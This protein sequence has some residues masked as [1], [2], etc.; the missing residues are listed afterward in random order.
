[1]SPGRRSGSADDASSRT[2]DGS[3]RAGRPSLGQRRARC[4]CCCTW[5]RTQRANLLRQA[6][7]ADLGE[8]TAVRIDRVGDDLLVRHGVRGLPFRVTQGAD[9][10]PRI[11]I[12]AAQLV[13]LGFEPGLY[14]LCEAVDKELRIDVGAGPAPEPD[15]PS[16]P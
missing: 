5:R 11:S 8:P 3:S 1:M 15:L 14:L 13:A 10:Q 6:T 12:G 4:A 7:L 16:E 9:G 2:A